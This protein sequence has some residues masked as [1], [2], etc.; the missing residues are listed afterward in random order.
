[1]KWI[2]LA[3]LTCC[4]PAVTAIPSSLPHVR[5][6]ETLPGAVMS[7]DAAIVIVS[8]RIDEKTKCDARV[9]DCETRALTAEHGRDEAVKL[10]QQHAWWGTWGPTAVLTA[11]L[12][13]IGIGFAA[14][15]GSAPRK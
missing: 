5:V 12:V 6:D 9:T 10:A 1:V 2:A 3:L 7:K 13:A 4:A 8:K 14:G 11:A 15:F